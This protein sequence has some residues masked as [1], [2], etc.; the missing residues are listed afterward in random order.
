MVPK[1]KKEALSKVKN[2]V[3]SGTNFWNPGD[4]FVRDGVI[5]I[6]ENLFQGYQINFLFYNFNQDFFPQSK[7]AG[8]T[9][10]AA[11]GDLNKYSEHVDAVVIAGLSA[12]LEINDL[13]NW[14]VDTNLLDRVYLIGA[15]YENDYVDKHI[16]QEPAATIF[17]NARIITG[18][19]RKKPKFISDYNLPYHH[20]NCP[21][22]LSVPNV[23]D[24]NQ[25]KRIENIAFSIQLPHQIGIMNQSC[26]ESMHK[27]AMNILFKLYHEHKIEVIAHHKSEYFYFVKLFQEL[28]LSVPVIFSSFYRD[29]FNTYRQYD[30][31]IATR[32]HACLF[33]NGHGI[34][35]IVLNDTD[36]HTHCLDGFLHSVWVNSREKFDSVFREVQSLDLVLVTE[37][38]EKFKDNL[39]D[40]Y[41]NVLEEPFGLNVEKINTFDGT[42]FSKYRQL[43]STLDHKDQKNYGFDKMQSVSNK[44]GGTTNDCFEKK[45][46]E[47][48]IDTLAGDLDTK[49]RVLNIFSRLTK[50]YWLE[51]NIENYRRLIQNRVRC[52]DA[53][54]FLNWYAEHFKPRSY[55]EVGVRRGRSIAQVLGSISCNDG[56]RFRYVDSGLWLQARR[57]HL[58]K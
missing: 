41:L 7:F 51:K 4:D 46:A 55:L 58:Y 3:I 22:I 29:M 28:G 14:I 6:L 25:G 57:W 44:S 12:G 47:R 52:F 16:S 13:Y 48:L 45:L 56:F 32:L 34:P 18:R 11:K 39:L 37:E 35:G 50:D 15:G 33:G 42:Q 21:A 31:I 40:Q 49:R 17:K 10:M 20:L 38:A 54:S 19:T 26:S 8:I 2:I 5:K 30:L 23:K 24:V 9:N 36:R 27:L 43:P 1:P 53:A